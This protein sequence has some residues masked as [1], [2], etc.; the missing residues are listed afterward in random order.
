MNLKRILAFLMAGMVLTGC[1]R[2]ISLAI[3]PG[4]RVVLSRYGKIEELS[5]LDPRYTELE[6]WLASNQDGWEPYWATEPGQGISIQAGTLRI[7]FLKGRAMVDTGSGLF[8]KRVKPSDYEF[9]G[10]DQKLEK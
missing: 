9:F 3:P 8:Q 5:V 4:S 2:H 6:H 1:G 7:R 10:V